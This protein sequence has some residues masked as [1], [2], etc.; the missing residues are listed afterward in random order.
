MSF[1]SASIPAVRGTAIEPLEPTLFGPWSLMS[2]TSPARGLVCRGRSF[3]ARTNRVFREDFRNPLERLLRRRLRLHTVLD[4]VHP[5]LHKGMLVWTCARAGL[6]THHCGRVGPSRPC[7]TYAFR[8]GS[9][10]RHGSLFAIE[11]MQGMR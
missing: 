11:G 6:K 3:S 8:C 5:T 4:D 1:R 2:E 9:A 7:S 10:D